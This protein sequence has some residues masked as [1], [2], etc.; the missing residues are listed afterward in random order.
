MGKGGQNTA[1]VQQHDTLTWQEVQK[2]STRKDK[3]IVVDGEVY[4][5][6]NWSRK[7]PGGSRMLSH[8]AGQ[9]ATVSSMPSCTVFSLIAWDWT[10]FG[11]LSE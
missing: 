6:T 8:Y 11:R 9:D 7:H 3:W 5:V 1:E 2:H 10:F 4:N